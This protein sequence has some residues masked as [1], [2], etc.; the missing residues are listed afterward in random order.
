MTSTLPRNL[1]AFPFVTVAEFNDI[2]DVF[3][4]A[5]YATKEPVG[6]WTSVQ[7]LAAVRCHSLEPDIHRS[8]NS[9]Q[10]QG[11]LIRIRRDVDIAKRR[12]DSPEKHAKDSQPRSLPSALVEHTPDREGG[13]DDEGDFDEVL[14]NELW[15]LYWA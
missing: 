14:Q 15:F 3:Y 9:V 7:V 13:F 1:T 6:S 2:C 5:Y 8:L 12:V 10:T 11:K 4:A